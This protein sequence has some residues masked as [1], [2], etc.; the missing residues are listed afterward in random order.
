MICFACILCLCA[1]SKLA[2]AGQWLM[3]YQQ[4]YMLTIQVLVRYLSTHTW[5]VDLLTAI[6]ALGLLLTQKSQGK[7]CVKPEAC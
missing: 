5:S 7:V 4:F 6:G 1:T 2:M 3:H